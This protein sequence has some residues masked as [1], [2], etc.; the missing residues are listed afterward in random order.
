[1]KLHLLN[2]IK[3]DLLNDTQRAIIYKSFFEDNDTI[4]LKNIIFIQHNIINDFQNNIQNCSTQI[5][6]LK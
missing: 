2:L 5:N 6:T 4:F 3:K 1:M